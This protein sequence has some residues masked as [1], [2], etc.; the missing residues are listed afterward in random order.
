MKL[1]F[2][3]ILYTIII[4]LFAI[5][6]AIAFGLSGGIFVAKVSPGD[7]IEQ[8]LTVTTSKN[9]S[10]LNVTVNI[11]DMLQGPHGETLARDLSSAGPYS[12]RSFLRISPSRFH[13]EPGGNQKII[14]EGDIPS[15]ASPGGKYAIVNIRS[16]PN[17]I[18]VSKSASGISFGMAINGIVELMI[19]SDKAAK[20]GVITNLSV[21]KP[22]LAKQQNISITYNNTG[23]IHYNI[24][25]SAVLTDENKKVLAD[26]N[27]TSSI[28]IMPG[29]LRIIGLSLIPKKALGPGTYDINAT[30]QLDNGTVLASNQT[31]LE[32]T[33]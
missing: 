8:G 28:P 26:A 19:S 13:I 17:Q 10:P 7:H 33:A 6:L 23:N 5:S 9:D 1:R 25:T 2:K 22:T 3:I 11:L 4:L 31:K 21:Q 14:L 20:A 12:A 30:V 18:G 16:V 24:K 27:T 32:I 15:Q 29:A